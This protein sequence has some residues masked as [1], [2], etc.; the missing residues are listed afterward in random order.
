MITM[1]NILSEPLI[2]KTSNPG[3]FI[4]HLKIAIG[5]LNIDPK[6]IEIIEGE[7]KVTIPSISP[8]LLGA[9]FIYF[10]RSK[11]V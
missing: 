3:I 6:D 9:I 1:P 4:L 7:N 11:I 5:E 2:L 10:S 8:E